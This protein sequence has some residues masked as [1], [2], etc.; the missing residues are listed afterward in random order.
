M[1]LKFHLKEVKIIILI[2]LLFPSLIKAQNTSQTSEINPDSTK[3]I[4]KKA[5]HSLFAGAGYGSNMIYLGSTISLDKPFEYASITYG[6][7]NTFYLSGSATHIA[8]INPFA[9]I[10]TI[11]AAYNHTFNSWFDL[12][13]GISRYEVPFTLEDTLFSSFM[14]GEADFGIDW[15]ILYT[16]LCVGGILAEEDNMYFQ[17]KNSRYFQTP[18]FTRKKLYVSF[19][20]YINLLFGTL[21]KSET[22]TGTVVNISP[23]FRKQGNSGTHSTTTT[24]YTNVFGI[25]ELDMGIP[26]TLNSTNLTIE[27]EPGYIY[28]VYEDAVYPGTKG[29]IFMFSAFVRIF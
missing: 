5:V 11:S 14:Y 23:P 9:A 4:T 12:G 6:L 17:I 2:F 22:T 24:K 16:K 26:I 29:F 15:R 7:N 20:P 25:M 13:A 1:K 21:T 28:P 27:A 8:D 19:D 18:E 10:Y 3:S